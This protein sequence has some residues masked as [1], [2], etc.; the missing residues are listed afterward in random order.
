MFS[1][2][3]FSLSVC[4]VPYWKGQFNEKVK[5]VR[6]YGKNDGV[7]VESWQKKDIEFGRGLGHTN[8]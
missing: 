2:L 7:Q 4:F 1:I 3:F 8:P 5:V 6:A